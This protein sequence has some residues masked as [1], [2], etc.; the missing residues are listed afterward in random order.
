[1]KVY[2]W[3]KMSII[4]HSMGGQ[5]ALFFAA[6]FPDRVDMV[7]NIDG[8]KPLNRVHSVL[9]SDLKDSLENCMRA[10][11]RNQSDKEPPAYTIDEM[12]EKTYHGSFE[13]VYREYAPYLLKRHIEPSKKHPGKFLFTFDGRLRHR[14]DFNRPLSLYVDLAKQI[15]IPYLAIKGYAIP[16]FDEKE[17]YDVMLNAMR[18][19]ENF[20]FFLPN[21]LKHHM[22]LTD[23]EKIAGTISEFILKYKTA[24]SHL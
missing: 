1:M 15:K 8:L 19:S 11:E 3:T 23:P 9:K 22:H 24:K 4:A 7:I 5:V 6:I 16:M 12:V 18:E 13:S 10:D 14:V 20:E 21:K 2:N 17:N